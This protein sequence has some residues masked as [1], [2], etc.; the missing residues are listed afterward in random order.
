[1]IPGLARLAEAVHENGAKICLQL[2]HGGRRS[3][4]ESTAPSPIPFDK[5]HPT[6]RGADNR[7]TYIYW[8]M[9]S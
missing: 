8:W 1:M 2:Q 7:Y 6:P 5:G 3:C 9:I 4:V